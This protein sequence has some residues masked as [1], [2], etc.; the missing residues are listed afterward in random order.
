MR[1]VV[2]SRAREVMVAGHSRQMRSTGSNPAGSTRIPRRPTRAVLVFWTIKQC[3][4]TATEQDIL[5]ILDK[6]LSYMKRI[7]VIVH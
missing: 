4:N 3:S 6:Y 2:R 1:C 7:L 5:R